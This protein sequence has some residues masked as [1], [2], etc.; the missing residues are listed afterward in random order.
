MKFMH[1]AYIVA[2]LR[3]AVTK[4]KRVDDVM[5]GNALPKAE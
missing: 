3:T 5:V 1:E 2:G 4:A